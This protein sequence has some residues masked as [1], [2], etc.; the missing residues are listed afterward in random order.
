[1]KLT[2]ILQVKAQFIITEV[3][4]G[5][6]LQRQ[7]SQLHSPGRALR[8]RRT[9]GI[10]ALLSQF[11]LLLKTWQMK[12]SR[13]MLHNLIRFLKNGRKC[14]VKLGKLFILILLNKVVAFPVARYHLE[15]SGDHNDIEALVF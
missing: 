10:C 2:C 11:P 5:S 12:V 6:R 15:K 9:P 14:W 8:Y 4:A 3:E 1:M 7:N 13:C